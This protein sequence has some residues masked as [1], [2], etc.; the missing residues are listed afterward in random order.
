M[1]APRP[2]RELVEIGTARQRAVA[3][4]IL[5]RKSAAAGDV[6]TVAS[7]AVVL[8]RMRRGGVA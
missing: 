8:E 6:P 3:L 7:A 1:I 4:A 5:L 2:T